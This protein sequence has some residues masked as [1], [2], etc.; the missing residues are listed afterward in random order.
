MRNDI[1]VRVSLNFKKSLD[2]LYPNA[3]SIRIK[4]E[5]LNSILEEIL[6]GKK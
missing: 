2:K 6:Y 4:T 5:K 3:K 1:Q